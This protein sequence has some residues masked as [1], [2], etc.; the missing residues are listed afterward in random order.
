[1]AILECSS[2]DA[3]IVSPVKRLL[4]LKNIRLDVLVCDLAMPDMDGYELSAL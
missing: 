2:A 3:T 1:M 4:R